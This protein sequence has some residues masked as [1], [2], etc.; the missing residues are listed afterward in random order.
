MTYQ[1]E[2]NHFYDAINV[3]Y[4]TYV[5]GTLSQSGSNE[6]L[7]FRTGWITVRKVIWP[8]FIS[9][10]SK[11]RFIR[12]SQRRNHHRFLGVQDKHPSLP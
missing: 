3:D 7:G 6:T 2:L 1:E 4:A 5:A 10:V 8:I 11:N 9:S 12:C